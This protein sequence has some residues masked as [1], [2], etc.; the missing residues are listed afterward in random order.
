M[1]KQISAVLIDHMGTDLTTVNAA[2]VSYG[3]ESKSLT[4]RDSHLIS[5]LA[6]HEHVTPFRHAHVTLRCRAP[7]FLARQLGKH[8]VGFSWNEISR[9]YKDGEAIEIECYIPDTVLCRPAKLMTE[10]AAPMAQD[11]AEDAEHIIHSANESAIRQYKT[12]IDYGVAPEQARM[13]LPQSMITEWIWT[14]SLYGWANLYNQRS[15][16]H[17]QLEARL[18]AAEVDKIMSELFPNCWKALTNKG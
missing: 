17:A 8:Q 10:S 15:T 1:S 7:I 6:E 9:R 5:F 13:V 2:R 12:L 18:F 3:A 4:E 11:F 14:G 16:S